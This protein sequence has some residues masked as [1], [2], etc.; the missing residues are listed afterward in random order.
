[1]AVTVLLGLFGNQTVFQP[2][3]AIVSEISGN[4]LW[5]IKCMT[6]ASM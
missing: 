1:M 5:L 2:L 4:K 6:T 3:L